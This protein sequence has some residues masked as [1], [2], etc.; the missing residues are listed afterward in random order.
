MY[1]VVYTGLYIRGCTY[2]LR[3]FTEC[4]ERLTRAFMECIVRLL[5][6]FVLTPTV[7]A[8]NAI[9]GPCTAFTECN[10]RVFFGIMMYGRVRYGNYI[11]SQ[12]L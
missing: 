12:A 9:Y 7:S 5:N 8:R 2:G 11:F 4:K 1:G 10:V 3:A 6:I